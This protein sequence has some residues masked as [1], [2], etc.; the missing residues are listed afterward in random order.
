MVYLSLGSNFGDRFGF[1]EKAIRKIEEK[2]GRVVS[3]SPVYE[4][5]AWGY[6][7]AAFLNACLGIETEKSPEEVLKSLLAIE[8][9]LGRIRNQGQ[10]YQ[11]RTIDLDLLLYDALILESPTLEL[12]HP[13]NEFTPIYSY[14]LKRYCWRSFASPTAE[15]Y[16]HPEERMPRQRRIEPLERRFYFFRELNF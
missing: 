9:S 1:L 13:Q 5:P 7:G 14:A 12:P 10:G 2:I 16:K 3:L 6:K 11:D 15:K 8:E 4:T